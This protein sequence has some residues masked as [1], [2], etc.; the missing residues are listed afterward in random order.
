M[1]IVKVMSKT[2]SKDTGCFEYVW[3]LCVSVQIDKMVYHI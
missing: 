3:M 1:L 2:R